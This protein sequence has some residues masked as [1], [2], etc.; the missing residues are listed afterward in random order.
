VNLLRDTSWDQ[1]VAFAEFAED[2]NFTRAAGRLH[3]SQPA[4]HTKI[5]NLGK[6]LDAILYVRRGRQIEITA[7]GRKVQRFARELSQA[8]AD[9]QSDLHGTRNE[10]PVVL[11]AGE[12]SYLYLLGAG[13]QAFRARSRHALRLETADGASALEAVQSARAQLG[14]A[15]LESAPAGLAAEPLTRV[16]QM[17]AIPAAHRLAN[18]RTVRL[19]DLEGEALIVPPAGRPHRAMISHVMHSAGVSW[20][21]AMEASGWEPMMQFVRLGMGA[22]VVNACCRLPRGVVARA[23][24]ELPSQQYYLFHRERSLRRPVSD[25]KRAL[26]ERANAWKDAGN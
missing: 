8:A 17:L 15:S 9:F 14:V 4:L 1:L 23:M 13:I 10:E 24:P 20:H 11:S 21:V 3:L 25:L 5:V 22:A 2:A 7:A 19:R 18:R 16:G 6:A 26:L 12:G